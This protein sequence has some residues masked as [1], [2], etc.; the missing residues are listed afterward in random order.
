GD[1]EQQSDRALCQREEVQPRLQV[2]HQLGALADQLY[3]QRANEAISGLG[4][5]QPQ[6]Q[7][8]QHHHHRQLAASATT[9]DTKPV[10]C[11]PPSPVALPLPPSHSPLYH[12][13]P[14]CNLYLSVFPF[15]SF[16]AVPLLTLSCN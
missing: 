7:H 16:T 10:P 6:Q 5:C 11:S 3:S 12:R 14:F 9:C 1:A 8:H 2:P 15:V 13:L 4:L